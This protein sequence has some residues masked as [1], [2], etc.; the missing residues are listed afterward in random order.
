MMVA[1][2]AGETLRQFAVKAPRFEAYFKAYIRSWDETVFRS[3][4]NHPE[5][6]GWVS[7]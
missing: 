7:S 6:K 1:L 2:R 5:T 4:R 3:R